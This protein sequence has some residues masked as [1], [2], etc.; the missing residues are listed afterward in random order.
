MN[1]QQH[2][3]CYDNVLV[4][5]LVILCIAQCAADRESSGTAPALR[6]QGESTRQI[7]AQPFS[8]PQMIHYSSHTMEDLF[9]Q[10][11]GPLLRVNASLVEDGLAFLEQAPARLK[12]G[13][14]LVWEMRIAPFVVK[15]AI[16]IGGPSIR[17]Q[18]ELAAELQQF[19]KMLQSTKAPKHLCLPVV[20]RLLIASII[21]QDIKFGS[22]KWTQELKNAVTDVLLA[23]F[24]VHKRGAALKAA[25]EF[26][27]VSKAGGTSMCELSV[28]NGCNASDTTLYGNC[29]MRRFNDGPRWVSHIE[30]NKTMPLPATENG[31]N[32]RWFYR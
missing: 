29:L 7:L 30:H 15:K 23:L 9:R 3:H 2:F 21:K 22:E 19:A 18:A 11:F 12:G 1:P 26:F 20:R 6:K 32:L 13:L 5:G 14:E 8:K 16:S 25:M 28:M 10:R 31:S 27:H 4:I 17:R 24:H